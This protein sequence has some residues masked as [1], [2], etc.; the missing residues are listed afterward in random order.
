MPVSGGDTRDTRSV[1]RQDSSDWLQLMIARDADVADALAV[2]AEHGRTK[3][4]RNG[5]RNNL[6]RHRNDQPSRTFRPRPG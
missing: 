4:I 5:A 6:R 2:L 1:G 3:R